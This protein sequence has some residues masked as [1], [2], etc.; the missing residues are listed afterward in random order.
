[1]ALVFTGLS[2]E[3]VRHIASCSHPPIDMQRLCL[4]RT[5]RGLYARR[6]LL[7]RRY[8]LGH[9]V[10]SPARGQSTIN[11]DAD[12]GCAASVGL[13]AEGGGKQSTAGPLTDRQA[14]DISSHAG[15]GCAGRRGICGVGCPHQELAIGVQHCRCARHQWKGDDSAPLPKL[16]A[17]QQRSP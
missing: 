3:S 15:I 13:G 10:L 14:N 16:H 1:M 17:A 7:R 9:I 2:A 6:L 5:C 4:G 8:Q 11:Q 12:R